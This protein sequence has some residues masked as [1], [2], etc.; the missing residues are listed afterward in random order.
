MEK[1]YPAPFPARQVKNMVVG[2]FFYN[3]GKK[4]RITRIE[5]AYIDSTNKPAFDSWA[6]SEQEDIPRPTAA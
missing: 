4:M 3:H 5:T 2:T 1:K 6:V